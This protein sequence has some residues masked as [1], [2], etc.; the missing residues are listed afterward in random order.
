MSTQGLPA[1]LDKYITTRDK[2]L[3]RWEGDAQLRTLFNELLQR[4]KVRVGGR[5]TCGVWVDA[6]WEVFTAWGEVVKKAVKLG[7]D[8][9]V[10]PLPQKN[11][12]PT[13]AGGW[14]YENEYYLHHK[15]QENVDRTDRK[16]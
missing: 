5:S 9:S 3:G 2:R 7:Y 11:G 8:I 13:V 16:T 10:T 14:W 15:G 6:S 1:A 4:K 12:N